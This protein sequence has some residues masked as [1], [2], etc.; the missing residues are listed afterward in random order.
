MKSTKLLFEDNILV[1]SYQYKGLHV[2]P[3]YLELGSLL[4]SK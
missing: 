2:R 3:Y 4:K 1:D